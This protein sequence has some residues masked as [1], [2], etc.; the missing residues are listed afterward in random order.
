MDA[1]EFYLCRVLLNGEARLV[2]WYTDDIDGFLRDSAGRLVIAESVATLGVPLGGPEPVDYDF[3]RI[4]SWCASPDVATV[5]CS[6]FLDAWNFLDDLAGLH[7]EADSPYVRMSREAVTVYDK[8]FWS[9]NLP[10][11]TPVGEQYTPAWS[12]EELLTIRDVFE[13]GLY[14]LEGELAG[15]VYG[16]SRDSDSAS[17]QR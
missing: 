16:R 14:A 5:D 11:V 10:A 12:S 9:N 2:A 15:D 1:R 6:A 4:R 3:D 17:D 7:T 13:A 8:L